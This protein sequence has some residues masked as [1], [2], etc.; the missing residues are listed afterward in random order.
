MTTLG[1]QINGGMPILLNQLTDAY[2]SATAVVEEENRVKD[3]W[4]DEA[5]VEA[6]SINEISLP[7]S[8]LTAPVSLE[9]RD[10]MVRIQ[11]AIQKLPQTQRMMVYQYY[12]LE[13]KMREIAEIL[14]CPEGTVKV[15]LL[16]RQSSLKLSDLFLGTIR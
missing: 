10:T 8:L 13:L 4:S 11:Q 5:L 15:Y 14:D 1:L 2:R 12:W 6:D 3:P 7:D 9:G 16:V